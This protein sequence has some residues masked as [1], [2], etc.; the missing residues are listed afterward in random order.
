MRELLLGKLVLLDAAA[1]KVYN[2]RITID[3][4]RF[5][6]VTSLSLSWLPGLRMPACQHGLQ[7]FLES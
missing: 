5:Q 3:F 4:F 6:K 7:L 2:R 1:M